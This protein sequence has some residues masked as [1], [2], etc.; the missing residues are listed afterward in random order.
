[1][2]LSKIELM[3]CPPLLYGALDAICSNDYLHNSHFGN[4]FVL[5]YDDNEIVLAIL[6]SSNS[7][8]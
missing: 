1:M 3:T 6:G 5:E 2:P 7:I 4:I 8:F